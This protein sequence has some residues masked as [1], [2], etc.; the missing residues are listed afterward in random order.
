MLLQ[1]QLKNH[2]SIMGCH[3]EFWIFL[4]NVFFFS[5]VEPL[6]AIRLLAT[7][8]SGAGHFSSSPSASGNHH[9]VWSHDM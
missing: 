7:N 6:Y 8:A 4:E 2:A 9:L 3:Q 1:N 5:P